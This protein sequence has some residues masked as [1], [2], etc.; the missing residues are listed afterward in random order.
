MEIFD[1]TAH[2]LSDLLEKKEVTD[3]EITSAVLK[4][5]H[6]IDGDIRAYVT[7]TEENALHAAKNVHERRNKGDALPPLAGIPMAL[8][9]NI[10]TRGVRTTCSS[11]MLENF[12]PPYSATV[13]DRLL[14]NSAV[15]LGKLNMDEFAMGSSTESSYFFPTRNPWD[16]DRVPGGSS[17]GSA[18][19]VA[20]GEAVFALGSDTGGSIRQPAAFCGIV[21]MKPTY[22]LVSRS[23]VVAFASS[24]DQVGPLT[25]DVRDCALVMNA[26]AG[27]D[28]LDS[29]SVKRNVPDYTTFLTGEVKGKRIGVVREMIDDGLNPRVAEVFKK[30]VNKLEGLGAV[31]D[32]CSL[33]VAAASSVP[34]YHIIAPAEA[35]SNLARFDGVRFGYR[36]VPEKGEK[37]TLE[38][39]YMKTRGKGFGP[40]VK[41]RIMMGTYVLSSGSYEKYYIKAAKVRTLIKKE[42]EQAYER[43]DVLITPTTPDLPFLLGE[44]V[45]PLDSYDSDKYTV[46]VNIAGLPA[47]SIP[48]GFVDGL[49]VGM[50]IIAPAFREDSLFQV[51]YAFEQNTPYH[52]ERPPIKRRA[53]EEKAKG[54]DIDD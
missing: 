6:Q 36:A 48:C 41:R 33:P 11:R 16:I 12:I 29:T 53:S 20:A 8:K 49:P 2:E 44:K 30:A 18:A 39:M 46:P 38:E 24:M 43:F 54:S 4:R 51:A 17:G 1:L 13:V 34:V 7:I 52:R 50:Q 37:Y 19:A 28:P 10:C 5:I 21:G 25:K 40:E 3:I 31:V 26:I 47:I 9:D 14:E 32:E 22:G 45:N 42:F 23:G 35:S 15:L 27:Y